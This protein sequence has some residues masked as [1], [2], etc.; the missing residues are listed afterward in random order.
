MKR[1]QRLIDETALPDDDARWAQSQAAAER[2]TQHGYI[3]IGLD[4]FARPDDELARSFAAG[5]LRRNFQGYTTDKAGALLGLGPS[6]IGE[7]PQGYVQNAAE[8]GAWGRAIAAGAFAIVR[9][10]ALDDDDR[11]R[12]D[13]I[14]RLMSD[15]HVDLGDIAHRYGRNANIFAPERPALRR[16]DDDGLITQE[17]ERIA[18]TAQ[19]RPLMRAVAAIFD[20]YLKPETK[21][22]SRAI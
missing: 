22:H 2:L 20:R 11:L 16:L 7:L 18:L 9:G 3:W 10:I 8:P 5:R 17:G 12:R 13:V 14:E 6:A 1:H 15:L 19:G 4:H 21:R